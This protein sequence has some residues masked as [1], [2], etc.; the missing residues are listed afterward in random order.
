M[1]VDISKQQNDFRLSIK[2][3]ARPNKVVI[4]QAYVFVKQPVWVLYHFIGLLCDKRKTDANYQLL[5]I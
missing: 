2:C 4:R 1:S 5:S 3:L